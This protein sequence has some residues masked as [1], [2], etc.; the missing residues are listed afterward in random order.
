VRMKNFVSQSSPAAA[1]LRNYVVRTM[2]VT[3]GLR[4]YIREVRF[5]PPPT[6]PQGSYLGLPRKRRKSAEG[7]PVQ[8]PQVRSFDG[9]RALL[10]EFLGEGSRC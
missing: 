6:Y 1:A 7:R 4:D 8:Q 3:P 5:K 10:D 9:T 2:L